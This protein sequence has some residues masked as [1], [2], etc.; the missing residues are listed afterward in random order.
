MAVAATKVSVGYRAGSNVEAEISYVGPNAAASGAL[1]ADIVATRLTGVPVRVEVLGGET[2]CRLRAAAISHDG[3]LLDRVADEV[4]SPVH[5]RSRRRRGVP[6]ARHRGDRHR[7]HHG[8]APRGPSRV[9]F[10]EAS[11]AAT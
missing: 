8:P 5:Q 4:E 6:G 7:L 10:L 9:T 2:D 3:A 11:D 1:A